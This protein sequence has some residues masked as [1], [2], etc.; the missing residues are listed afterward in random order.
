MSKFSSAVKFDVEKFDGR[1]NFGL[2]QV[3]VKDVLI[4]SGLHKA[5]E[6]KVSSKDSEK[7]ESSMSDGDW[8]ELDLRAA[9]TIRL[10]LAKNVLAN[11]QG[12]STAKELWKKLEGLYQAKG[13]SNWLM[14]KE[15]FHTL[16]MDEGT[17]ISDHLS[18]LNSIVSELEA[19]AVKIDDEDKTLRLIWSLPSSYEYMKQILIDGRKKYGKNVTCWKCGKSGHVKKNCPGGASLAN[20]SELD[21]SSVSLVRGEG[22]FL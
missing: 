22:D 16:C 20:G 21:A 1:I 15:Q 2:W 14:L 12:I 9:S 8:E 17:K 5:L 7:S 18:T 11:V 13:I 10:S 4:Q 3:Q 6:G 19:I